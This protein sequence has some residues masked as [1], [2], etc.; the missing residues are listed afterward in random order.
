MDSVRPFRAFVSYCHADAVFAARLQRR[1]EAYRLPRRLVDRVAPLPGQGQ[2]R[3]GPIFRDRD[4]LSAA[5]DLS[6]AVRAAIAAS[7]ALIV[8]ASPDA[9]G[10]HWVTRE[11][12][13]FRELHPKALVLVALVRGEPDAALPGA[14]V[15]GGVEPLAA[16]FRQNGDGERL[17]FLKIVAGLVGVPLDALVQRD[18]QRR[19][20]RVMTVTLGAVA[21]TL[22]MIAVTAFALVSRAQAV[23]E[24][25][26]AE[27]L[28]EFMLT[29]LRE[30]LRGVG[31]LDV[32]EQV[33][34]RAMSYYAAQGNL[35]HLPDE[36]LL[37]RARIL[38]AMG[39]DDSERDQAKA[40]LAKF[41]AA[42]RVT[43][44]LLARRPNDTDRIYAHAQSE[45]WLGSAAW[46]VDDFAPAKRHFEQYSVL[47]KRL[48]TINAANRDWQMEGGYAESNLGTFALQ[49]EKR[50]DA[51]QV[52][53]ERSLQ[54][55]EHARR[56]APGDVSIVRELADGFGWL[57]DSERVQGRYGDA[58]THRLKERALLDSLAAADPRNAKL[59][60]GLVGSSVGLA[61]LEILLGRQDEAIARLRDAKATINLLVN[62]DRDNQTI[63][64][65]QEMV[66]LRLASALRLRGGLGADDRAL[67][68]STRDYCTNKKEFIKTTDEAHLCED[69]LK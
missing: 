16:D 42:H 8:I 53:F 9:A 37:R 44:M 33:N 5:E 3:V 51:A 45:F 55:F 25:N 30:K 38:H 29:D 2:G 23:S 65:Q 68:L 50:P 21:I 20:R 61:R 24:R 11:I 36:S 27:G 47:A 6:A 19:L 66:A 43:G 4:D 46:K 67:I 15:A 56:L 17:A 14:L 10:S 12:D 22:L 35:S 64:R 7:S 54:Y 60:R 26:Q 59:E 1:L 41:T 13:L 48:I 52:A 39:E 31:R 69:I 58:Y 57:A 32:M 62:R 34:Q 40:A 49:A 63:V 18:A 28:I